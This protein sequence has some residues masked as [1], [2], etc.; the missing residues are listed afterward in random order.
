MPAAFIN[1]S[2]RWRPEGLYVV[3]AAVV[4]ED[5]DDAR[6]AARAVLLRRQHRFH[7]RVESERQRLRMLGAL[8][9]VAERVMAYTCQPIPTSKQDR[10]RAQCLK[11]LLWDLR[12]LDVDELVFESRDEHNDRKD[13][14]TIVRAQNAQ[15]A[16]KLLGY[17]FRRPQEEPL[18]WL[19]D[20]AAGAVAM[21]TAEGITRFAGLLG[22]RLVVTAVDL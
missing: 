13:R 12:D 17:D 20:A 14:R 16:P 15:A 11:R 22:D 6:A 9:D 4:A 18:L 1:E 7:W 10:A 21:Q 8:V 19:P 3:A 2:L 5:L